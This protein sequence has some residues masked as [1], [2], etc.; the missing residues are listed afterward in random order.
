MPSRIR[1]AKHMSNW[2]EGNV[3]ANGINIHYHRTGTTGKSVLL[4]LHG[5]TDSGR[6]WQ[7]VARDLEEEYDTGMTDARGHGQSGDLSNGFSIP[8][9]GD[10]AAGV[11]R[12]L[13]LEKAYGWGHS[14]GAVTAAVLA[15]NYPDLV[16]A[17][18]LE[19][20][21]FLSTA[22][23]AKQRATAREEEAANSAE[24]F[25]D[26]RAMSSE[27][28]LTVASAMNPKWHPDELPPWAESKAQFDPAIGQHVGSFL[29]YPW[30]EVLAR[31]DCPTL[32][33]TGDPDAGAIVTPEVAR[34]AVALLKVGR[35]VRIA[36][37]GHNIHREGYE[38][39]MQVVKEFLRT[40]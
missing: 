3:A 4:L 8:I 34:E 38:Q 1:K 36:G 27:E 26:F 28:R 21:P 11:M 18:V 5:I 9:L 24:S 7:R 29:G 12:G 23:E 35:A 17:A 15:A 16:R 6:I 13:G 20:P 2:Y 37:S 32:L 25:P 14:M 22:A 33:V 10:D 39:T 30:R 40:Y 31:I 19:D